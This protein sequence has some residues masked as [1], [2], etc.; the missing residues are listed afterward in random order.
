LA[1]RSRWFTRA[2]GVPVFDRA[3]RERL[4]DVAAAARA[5]GADVSLGNWMCAIKML[6][7]NGSRPPTHGVPSIS[8]LP[9]RASQRASPRRHREDPQ[10]VRAIIGVNLIGVLN[11]VEP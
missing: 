1:A 8:S 3:D 10:A 4:E 9:M 11:T 6:C 5:Q 7:R 2:K